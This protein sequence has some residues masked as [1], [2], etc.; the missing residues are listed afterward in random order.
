MNYNPQNNETPCDLLQSLGLK[1]SADNATKSIIMERESGEKIS[2]R[3]FMSATPENLEGESFFGEL[4]MAIEYGE[5]EVLRFLSDDEIGKII[6]LE[7]LEFKKVMA[8]MR[9]EENEDNEGEE[10]KAGE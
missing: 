6:T 3:S 1:M 9:E 10:W 2:F 4:A 7:D 5:I 8:E